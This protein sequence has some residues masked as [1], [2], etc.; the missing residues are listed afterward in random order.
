MKTILFIDTSNSRNIYVRVERNGQKVEKK[1]PSKQAQAQMVLPIVEELLKGNK[2]TLK[3]V[4][5]I[6]VATGP[7]S[8]TGLRVGIAVAQ[9]LGKLLS[10]PV[11]GHPPGSVI[12]PT[13]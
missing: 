12:E 6:N 2:L 13:Y 11:N 5:E 10:I 4:T 8:F 3:D 9:V 7:G 1:A